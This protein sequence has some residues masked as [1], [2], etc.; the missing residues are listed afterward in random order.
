VLWRAPASNG[1][2]ITGYVV[3]ANGVAHQ[4]TGTSTTLTGFADGATVSVSVMATNA[5]G[6]SKAVSTTAK[7]LSAP[8][9][10]LTGK[11]VGYNSITVD[12]TV[13]SGGGSVTCKLA[14]SGVSTVGGSCTSIT[15]GGLAPG[16]AYTYTASVTNAA[17][18]KSAGGSATT[19]ALNGTVHC[20]STNG[21][22]DTGVGIYSAPMQDT[23]DQTNWDGHNGKRYPAYCKVA[24]GDGNQQASA[25]LHAAGYNNNKTSNMWVKISNS[26]VRYI[27]WI[28]FNLDAGDDLGMLPTC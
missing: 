8:T 3:T 14:V 16:T 1:K 18:T 13:G 2:P 17:A 12:F 11:S 25:T 22:C 7:T 23:S 20:V 6:N 5:A 27:P 24:G 9:I 28:W 21:Y 19:T 26:P 10:T 15:V 4:V